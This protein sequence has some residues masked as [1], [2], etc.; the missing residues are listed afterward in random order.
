MRKATVLIVSAMFVMSAGFLHAED[1]PLEQIQASIASGVEMILATQQDDGAFLL[2]AQHHPVFPLGSTGLAVLAL[3]YARPHL[4][5][6]L[7]ARTFEGIRKGIA[8]IAQRPVEQKTYSAGFI[9][10]ALYNESP[11][12]YSKLIGKYAAAL[13]AS[14]HVDEKNRGLWHYDLRLPARGTQKAK[15]KISPGSD[16][17]NTQIAILGLYYANRAGFQIPKRVWKNSQQAYLKSQFKEDPYNGG[18]GYRSKTTPPKKPTANMTIAG[19]ISLNICNEMLLK[20]SRQCKA[21]EKSKAIEDGLDWIDRNWK[22][23]QIGRDTYGL[24]ALERLGIIMGR[25]NIG[26]HDWFNEGAR[27]LVGKK[28]WYAQGGTPPVGACF[29]VMFLARGLEP[30][31]I[32]KLIRR[33]TQDW[34]NTPYDVKHLIEYI[35][36]HYQHRVQWRMV[37]LEAPMHVLQKTPIL[38][39]SGHD[40]LDFND[41]EKKKLKAYVDGGGT[42]LAQ[43]CCSMKPFASSF[44]KLIEE[45]F[46]G[47]LKALPKKHRIYERM[48]MRGYSPKPLIEVFSYAD[49]GNRP[50]VIFIP[51]GICRNW[52]LGGS[53]AKQS[54]VVGTGIYLY[55]TIEG[56]KMYLN[57][58]GKA[59]PS[60]KP[61]SSR[62]IR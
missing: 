37:S 33:D 38:H 36:D 24:Y 12:R 15:R 49:Q 43:A 41:E 35:Q 26:K 18:W 59:V 30:I 19:T 8:Y 53:R 54:F 10:C 2:T 29:G 52:H 23:Q 55:V 20:R 45:V 51:Y 58:R 42:I 3:Q 17:S 13:A 16:K 25:A 40:K 27:M 47:P 50:G 34:N 5:G 14:Q 39:I 57:A 4:E 9:I 22:S 6:D 62:Q 56:R 61:S 21:P 1:V 7:R 11:K 31:V 60:M 46:G 44:R 28:E 48:R 32:N